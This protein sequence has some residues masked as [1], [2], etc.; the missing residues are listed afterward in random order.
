[1]MEFTG[2]VLIIL[3][4]C[5]SDPN[6]T[7]TS[8]TIW[9][10]LSKLFDYLNT[11]RAQ[12]VQI[13]KGPLVSS[14]CSIRVAQLNNKHPIQSTLWIMKVKKYGKGVTLIFCQLF[15]LYGSYPSC[16]YQYVYKYRAGPLGHFGLLCPIILATNI[17]QAGQAQRPS[18]NQCIISLDMDSWQVIFHCYNYLHIIN[19]FIVIQQIT[20]NYELQPFKPREQKKVKVVVL[21]LLL[22]VDHSM[23]SNPSSS[24]FVGSTMRNAETKRISLSCI[25][26]DLNLNSLPIFN[27]V[28]LFLNI[29]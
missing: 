13:I 16:S 29:N 20:E 25:I 4:S 18:T 9:L 21:Y 3:I 1:M 23:I 2:K 12:W 6:K 15:S 5:W 26:S 11:S 14:V 19:N 24:M 8:V 28:Y 17:D 7:V 27:Y 22:V 10:W